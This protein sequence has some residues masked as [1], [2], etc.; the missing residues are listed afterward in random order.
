MERGYPTKFRGHGLAAWFR[1]DKGAAVSQWDDSSGNAR[2]LA[3]AT[4]SL[5]PTI[6]AGAQN[7]RPA[8]RLD[9][10][11]DYMETG[12]FTLNQ[13]ACIL[14][15][16]KS[17]SIQAAANHDIV[18]SNPGNNV[19]QISDTTPQLQQYAGGTG[20]AYAALVA[21][22]AY[23]QVTNIVNGVA[24]ILRVSKVQRATGNPGNSNPGGFRIG[25][26]VAGR[27][28][29]A[30]FMDCI[31]YSTV[32]SDSVIARLENYQAAFGGLAS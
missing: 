14:V 15:L 7:G 30:E 22:G 4:G 32:L 8:V 6:V 10:T 28:H 12:A 2:H 11:D 31:L 27:T 1:S 18:W 21:N 5:Q 23:A 16:Y 26:V 9:G 20:I 13:P 19:L 25:Y 29:S 3:Q 17:N 24:S